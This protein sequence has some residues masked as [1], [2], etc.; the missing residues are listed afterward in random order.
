MKS[1]NKIIR[2]ILEGKRVQYRYK[3]GGVYVFWHEL[4][5]LDR[6]LFE[7]LYRKNTK[8]KWRIL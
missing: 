8:I 4:Y 1:K 3:C 2:A 7:N 6:E 5:S